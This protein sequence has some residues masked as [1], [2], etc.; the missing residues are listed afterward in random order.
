MGF[1]RAGNDGGYWVSDVSVAKKDFLERRQNRS[2]NKKEF[3]VSDD[4][5]DI[6]LKLR[7]INFL[8]IIFASVIPVRIR[9]FRRLY[10][11]VHEQ[12]GKPLGRIRTSVL[13]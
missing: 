1:D 7:T 13:I 9:R 12:S 6:I 8:F 3:K 4:E 11:G 2:H 10:Y 5:K